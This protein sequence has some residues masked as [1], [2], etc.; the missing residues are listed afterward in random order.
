[1]F[2]GGMFFLSFFFHF[3][4][5]LQK[6]TLSKKENHLAKSIRG[7]SWRLHRKTH[8]KKQTCQLLFSLLVFLFPQFPFP[9]MFHKIMKTE[10]GQVFEEESV[11]VWARSHEVFP[12]NSLQGSPACIVPSICDGLKASES[13]SSAFCFSPH[14]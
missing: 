8:A 6:Y 12:R 14:V 13:H 4:F 2:V 10:V 1:M 11:S 7:I 5:Y 3:F 9:K